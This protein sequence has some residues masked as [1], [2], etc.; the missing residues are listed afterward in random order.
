MNSI[1]PA[2]SA[3]LSL[4]PQQN[5]ITA[6]AELKMEE[7]PSS[8]ATGSG[9]STVTL[10]EDA[11]IQSKNSTGLNT[12]Q[13]VQK[14]ISPESRAIESNQTSSDLTYAANL[15]NVTS[16]FAPKDPTSNG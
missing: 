15:Q 9:N 4:Q 14:A 10:S 2:L 5:Q 12:A 11:L 1:T 6:K 8:L 13:T 3:A 16:S 7:K